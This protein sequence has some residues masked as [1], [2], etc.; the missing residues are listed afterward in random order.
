M[1]ILLVFPRSFEPNAT[2]PLGISLL[3][4][5]LINSGHNVDILDQTVEP[6]KELDWSSYHVIGLT[7]LCATFHNG[8]TLA[9]HIR[10][11]NPTVSIIAGGPFPDSCAKEVLESGLVDLV[12][13]GE[14]EK[15]IVRVVNALQNGEPLLDITGLSF[16]REGE[17]INTGTADVINDLDSLPLPAY[18]L[19][20]LQK[21]CW[22]FDGPKVASLMSSR[23]CP[24]SCIFCTRGPAESKLMRYLSPERVVEWATMLVRTLG[25]QKIHFVDSIF[26][27]DQ[28]RAERICDLII[29]QNLV[30]AWTCSSRIDCVTPHLLEK[31]KAAGCEGI[32]AGIESGNDDILFRIKKGFTKD[33]VRTAARLFQTVNGP[34][35]NTSFIIGHPWDTRETIK[36]TCEFAR[37]LKKKY[38]VAS[39]L[40]LIMTPFPGT[41]LWD[42]AENWGMHISKDWEKFCKFSAKDDTSPLI[43]NFDTQFLS[44]EELLA[45]YRTAV[46]HY[47]SF[48]R[49]E[50]LRLELRRRF[51]LFYRVVR[52][53]N[54]RIL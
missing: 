37:E 26:T 50:F 51:P 29:E 20:P 19:L 35:L 16:L 7:L 2:P 48:G 21:Y 23:G 17:V 32:N 22:G 54:R 27:M 12:L 36:E 38:G 5:C 53:V 31:M 9:Q 41:P 39:V 49:M 4:A 47:G 24:Y 11:C 15:T 10:D 52:W 43:V 44:R 33:E 13:H 46:L 25:Y 45:L 1:K 34:A 28:Q 3:A 8:I 40:F 42:H 30:F 18:D 6:D 14:G